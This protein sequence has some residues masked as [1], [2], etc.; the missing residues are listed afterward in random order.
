MAGESALITA[1]L[2]YLL[3]PLE[4]DPHFKASLL[5]FYPDYYPCWTWEYGPCLLSKN[6]EFQTC[7]PE[8][9]VVEQSP[10]SNSSCGAVIPSVYGLCSILLSPKAERRRQSDVPGLR[11]QGVT[12]VLWFR[13][14]MSELRIQTL[15]V[16]DPSSPLRLLSKT[17]DPLLNKKASSS[18]ELSPKPLFSNSREPN[19]PHRNCRRM[20]PK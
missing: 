14:P 12:N 4:S 13:A 15:N 8:V 19:K 10:S 20:R 16:P 2:S 3:E 9:V 17:Q 6:P 7:V 18:C 1:Y 11:W 5:A